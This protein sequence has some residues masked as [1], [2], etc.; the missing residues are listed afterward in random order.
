M[1]PL[2]PIMTTIP[3]RFLSS[4]GMPDCCLRNLQALKPHVLCVVE[5]LCYIA[6]VIGNFQKLQVQMVMV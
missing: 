1:D 4:S 5:R 2:G 3:D 6:W